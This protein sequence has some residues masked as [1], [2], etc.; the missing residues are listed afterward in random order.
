[1]RLAP[2]LRTTTIA[3]AAV[4]IFAALFALQCAARRFNDRRTT[5]QDI[6]TQ[7]AEGLRDAKVLPLGS[8]GE[9][10]AGLALLGAG[11]LQ[12][13]PGAGDSGGTYTALNGGWRVYAGPE[14][15]SWIEIDPRTWRLLPRATVGAALKRIAAMDFYAQ[16]GSYRRMQ[17]LRSLPLEFA[18]GASAG[19]ATYEITP[20]F[21]DG[22]CVMLRL[23]PPPPKI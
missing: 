19:S 15:V 21:E 1:M 12:A 13:Q 6:Y 3:L 7:L 17:G 5:V 23:A 18:F 11:E 20:L 22:A 16:A 10:Q 8:I 2:P 4:L 9:M 14:G